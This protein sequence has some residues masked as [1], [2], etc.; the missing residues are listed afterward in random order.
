MRINNTLVAG[1]DIAEQFA[2]FFEK[3]VARIVGETAVNQ[4]VYNGRS[5]MAADPLM[6][7]T[8]PKISE[9]IKDLKLKNTEGYDRIP[10]RIL[11]IIN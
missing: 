3:E 2:I 6:F 4:N 1:H 5:K 7:M 8:S 9:Y 10:Q 11:V